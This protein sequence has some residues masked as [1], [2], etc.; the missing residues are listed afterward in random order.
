MLGRQ[1]ICCSPLRAVGSLAGS[2]ARSHT[3]RCRLHSILVHS[4]FE[5]ARPH[6]VTSNSLVTQCY[7]RG[8]VMHSFQRGL[9]WGV[10]K[11]L[12]YLRLRFFVVA[13]THGG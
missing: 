4:R 1:T 12:F 2:V 13:R 9:S 7:A 11:V 3:T 10:V 5:T 8:A 6:V